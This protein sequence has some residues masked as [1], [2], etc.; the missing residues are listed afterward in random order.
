[1]KQIYFYFFILLYIL[2]LIICTGYQPIQRVCVY[3]PL[4]VLVENKIYSSYDFNVPSLIEFAAKL[5]LGIYGI[6]R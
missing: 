2:V 6:T 4:M 5:K 3:N 1:M